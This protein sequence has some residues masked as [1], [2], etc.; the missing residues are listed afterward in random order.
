[1]KKLLITILF[2]FPVFVSAT[3]IFIEVDTL[4]ESINAIE[5]NIVLPEGFD[6]V[7]IN[8]GNSSITVW[9]DKP[10]L[11]PDE[12]VIHF[13]GVTPGGFS[14]KRIIMSLTGLVR[15]E[16]LSEITYKDVVAYKNDGEGTQARVT[17]MAVRGEI[18][19]D[20]LAPEPF[21]ITLD[22]SEYI[23]DGGLFATFLAQ[24]KGTGVDKYFASEKFLF[25]PKESDWQEVVSPYNVRDSWL[26]KK[27]YIKAVDASGNER[28]ESTALHN[29]K[30]LWIFFAIIILVICV[31]IFRRYSGWRSSPYSS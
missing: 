24:D 20:R 15:L 7:D 4:G 10:T 6:L 26:I 3:H 5:G 2:A 19:E 1:M 16:D 18:A 12:Q 21:A 8:I 29:R 17:L 30:Y 22:K 14:G 23:F 28:I 11:N 13:S 31:H 9:I 27:V 25:S